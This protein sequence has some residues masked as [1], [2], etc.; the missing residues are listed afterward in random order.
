MCTFFFHIIFFYLNIERVKCKLRKCVCPSY[1]LSTFTFN[2]TTKTVLSD[3]VTRLL[4]ILNNPLNIM[5]KNTYIIKFSLINIL[6]NE[7]KH[8]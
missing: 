1:S 4:H 3:K 8:K 2:K 7:N 5:V 6:P